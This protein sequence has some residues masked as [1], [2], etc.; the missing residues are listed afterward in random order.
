MRNAIFRIGIPAGIESLMFSGG[1]LITQAY[2]ASLGTVA[3]ASNYVASACAGFLQLPGAALQIACTTLVGQAMGRNAPAEARTMI[4]YT[5]FA[6]SFCLLVTGGIAFPLAGWL[7]RAFT[8]DQAVIDTSAWLLRLILLVSPFLWATSFL[9]PSG[10]RGAGD[11]KYPMVVSI[12]GMWIFR[13]SL[14]WVLAYPAGLGVVG[15][16]LAMF[17]DW[18]VRSVFFLARLA[19]KAWQKHTVHQERLR[20]DLP[21]RE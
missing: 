9:L 14:G 11:T 2:I 10:L 19:G 21:E 5:T 1:K 3:M 13:I 17:V 8:A 12:V 6:A 4:K 20:P 15:V 7:T 18:A 16:W